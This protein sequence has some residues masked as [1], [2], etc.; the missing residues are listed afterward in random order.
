LSTGRI[1]ILNK[2]ALDTANKK[3]EMDCAYLPGIGYYVNVT[4]MENSKTWMFGYKGQ[5]FEQYGKSMVLIKYPDGKT[6]N[7][8]ITF[9][10]SSE[11]PVVRLVYGADKAWLSSEPA[12]VYVGGRKKIKLKENEICYEDYDANYHCKKLLNAKLDVGED[13]FVFNPGDDDYIGFSKIKKEINGEMKLYL[14]VESGKGTTRF[15]I[16]V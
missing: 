7:G 9:Y 10:K 11:D 12:Y 15:A 6:H 14:K 5:D 3:G 8:I 2:T 4:D 16:R 13:G 1:G